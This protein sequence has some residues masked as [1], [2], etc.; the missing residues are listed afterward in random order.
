MDLHEYKRIKA[1]IRDKYYLDLVNLRKQYFLESGRWGARKSGIL[2]FV[3][4]AIVNEFAHDRDFTIKNIRKR[5]RILFPQFKKEP[6]SE[7]L[8]QALHRLRGRLIEETGRY[9]GRMVIYRILRE[10]R[11]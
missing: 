1:K 2:P 6:T 5:I 7:A 3:I 10:K 9:D 8:S 4:R 11:K